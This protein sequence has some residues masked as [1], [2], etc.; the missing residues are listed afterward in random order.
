MSVESFYCDF[1][2]QDPSFS[3]FRRVCYV[4]VRS[5]E[6]NAKIVEGS[7]K[8]GFVDDRFHNTGE[9]EKFGALSYDKIELVP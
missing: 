7:Q 2:C 4:P 5:V 6:R 9:R 8:V 1:W 3:A